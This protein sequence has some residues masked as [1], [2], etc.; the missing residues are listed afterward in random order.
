MGKYRFEKLT[1]SNIGKSFAIFY[2]S[3]YSITS[4]TR[5]RYLLYPGKDKIRPKTGHEGPE[6]E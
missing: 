2:R 5:T 3:P 6:W 1:S 4:Y